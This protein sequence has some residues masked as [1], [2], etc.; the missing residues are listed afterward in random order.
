MGIIVPESLKKAGHRGFQGEQDI[1]RGS[2][3]AIPT[4]SWGARLPGQACTK[5][6]L[7]RSWS[8]RQLPPGRGGLSSSRRWKMRPR[9]QL[10]LQSLQPDHGANTQST[11]GDSTPELRRRLTREQGPQACASVQHVPQFSSSEP[12]W[13][14]S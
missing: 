5:Q 12:S 2:P 4:S 7:L 11:A 13:Q 14:F 10:W 9:P 1:W 6:D 3:T 8:N